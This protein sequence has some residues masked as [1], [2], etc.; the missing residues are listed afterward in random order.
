MFDD[1]ADIEEGL[2]GEACIFF[3]CEDGLA[4]LP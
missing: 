3:T 4:S 2:F 1:S